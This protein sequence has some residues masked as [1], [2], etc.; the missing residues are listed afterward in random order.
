METDCDQQLLAKVCAGDQPALA[1]LYDRHAGQLLAVALR[2]LKSRADAEDLIHDVFLEVWQKANQYDSARGTVR[3]WLLIRLR[4]RAI[5][6]LRVLTLARERN[7]MAAAETEL[8]I[9][10][11]DPSISPDCARARQALAT[12]SA[13][14][15]TVVELG[16]FRGFSHQEIATRCQIPVGTVKSRLSAALAKLRQVFAT[17]QKQQEQGYATH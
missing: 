9:A 11:P 15:R 17:S 12:L 7:N 8:A 10:T 3:T 4:S 16:Y 2:I 1:A 13:E 14:Q 5:D 6:R